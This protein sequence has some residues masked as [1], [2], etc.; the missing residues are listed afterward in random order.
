MKL[1]DVKFQIGSGL[2][3]YWE[4]LSRWIIV[5]ARRDAREL[6]VPLVFLQAVGECDTLA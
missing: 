1:G 2:A 4:T 3:M 5:R 6:R